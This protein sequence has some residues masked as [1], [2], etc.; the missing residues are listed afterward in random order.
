MGRQPPG[1]R[2]GTHQSIPHIAPCRPDR[3]YGVT[4]TGPSA[5]N[6]PVEVRRLLRAARADVVDLGKGRRIET[7]SELKK[8]T[9]VKFNATYNP[10]YFTG[11]FESALVLVHL[12]PKM[13]VDLGKY[14][15]ADF[16]D[17]YE[18]HRRFGYHHW[19]LDPSYYSQ[20]DL[21]QVRFLRPFG[22]ID[23]IPESNPCCKRVNAALACDEKLQL[24]LIPY[25]SSAFEAGDFSTDGLQLHFERVLGTIAAYRRKYILFCGA[26]FDALLRLS[27][28]ETFR[29]DHS[30]HLATTNGKSKV[31]YR[32]SNV[33]FK[34][35]GRTIRAGIARS[36]ATRGIPMSAY[37]SRCY[38]LYEN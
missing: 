8:H 7:A 14:S 20:F 6:W 5:R 11:A 15:Y 9:G 31:K 23:F 4:R 24:E 33:A 3:P 21:K 25:A 30:F 18:R 26:V 13:S 29:Y 16:N 1:S 2:E 38:K 17:Y 19:I 36:F 34:Y 22:I 27:G 35:D 10:M 12:N 37:G 28:R 32:F